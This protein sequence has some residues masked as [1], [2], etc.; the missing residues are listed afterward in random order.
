MKQI[1]KLTLTLLLFTIATS[2]FTIKVSAGNDSNYDYWSH[3]RFTPYLRNES[4]LTLPESE[5]LQNLF[6]LAEL[7]MKNRIDAQRYFGQG[8]DQIVKENFNYRYERLLE[9]FAALTPPNK[10]TAKAQELIKQAMTEQSMF[11]NEWADAPYDQTPKYRRTF[12]RHEYVQS[13]HK[14]L[15]KAY[16]LLMRAY[17]KE[18][19]NNKQAFFDYLC[20]MDFI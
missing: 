20:A 19:A 2:S 5:Y 11:I 17:P 13:S 3:H 18:T 10:K 16:N 14:K 15:L 12:S 8:K 4:P 9:A 7:A 1:Q 6:I